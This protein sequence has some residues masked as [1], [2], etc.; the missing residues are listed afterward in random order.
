MSAGKGAIAS[1]IAPVH[2]AGWPFIASA[3]VLGMAL[4]LL[5]LPLL[6]L[7]ALLAAACAYFFRDPTR[8]TPDDPA[9]VVSPAD[10]RVQRVGLRRPPSELGL[11]EHPLP[12]VSVFLSVLDVHV[13]RTPAAGRVAA[14]VH[15]PGRFLNAA[16]DKSSDEN[17]RQG[18]VIA[19]PAGHRVGLVQIAGLIARRIVTF[20]GEGAV[21]AAGDRVG[22]IRFGSRCDVYLPEGVVPIVLEGQRAVAGET[23]LARLE[24]PQVIVSGRT[25]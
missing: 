2:R 19:T 5:W 8:V 7:G 24:G 17:E 23:V 9:L 1:V 21:L 14:K 16:S 15:H 22:L 10:G 3:L 25:S 18:W 12:C 20:A 6:W 11:G 13:N 4:A